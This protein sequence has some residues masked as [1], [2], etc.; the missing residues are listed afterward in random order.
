M[1]CAAAP[2]LVPKLLPAPSANK[3]HHHLGRLHS[4]R[5]YTCRPGARALRLNERDRPVHLFYVFN[6]ANA[7]DNVAALIDNGCVSAG[8]R[9]APTPHK[10]PPPKPRLLPRPCCPSTF[11][12]F[13]A[14]RQFAE[15]LLPVN[16]APLLAGLLLFWLSGALS[17][18]D[19][20]P[21]S[22][23]VRN[24]SA[25]LSRSA[26]CHHLW[27]L[28]IQIPSTGVPYPPLT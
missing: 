11:S 18:A 8:L 2:K 23:C 21:P 4:H 10:S 13:L 14:S 25:Q 20:P 26:D 24:V 15:L 16:T 19:D 12:C 28:Y 9:T 6:G 22:R 3:P 1:S 7:P 5:M 27:R 17:V